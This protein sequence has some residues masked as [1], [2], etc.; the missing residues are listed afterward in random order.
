ML[1]SHPLFHKLEE[2]F[3]EFDANSD[4]RISMLEWGG[5]EADIPID[6]RTILEKL[7][8]KRGELSFG[9]V[10]RT[11]LTKRRATAMER[12]KEQGSKQQRISKAKVKE[13][14]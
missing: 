8:Q 1:K 5:I 13:D 2:A 11:L 6:M 10:A 12:K 3:H 4:G 7:I 14:L 9:V